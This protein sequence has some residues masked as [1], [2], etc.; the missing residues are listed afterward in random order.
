M[1]VT[2]ILTDGV[3]NTAISRI[4][5]DLTLVGAAANVLWDK[6]AD[7]LIFAD[8]AK[9]VFGTG[10][11]L[12]IY[13]DGSNSYVTNA[14][15]ALKIATETSGIAITLGHSTSEVTVADNLTVTGTLTGTLATAAQGSVTSL[16]TL[17]TLTVDNI[18][19]NGT[20]IGHTSDT[21]A[22][23]ISSAGVVT[24]SATD[25]LITSGTT[26]HNEDV[27][28][29][30]ANY[31][32][33]WDKSDNQLE[34]GDN[35]KAVFG[36]SDD[37]Q[38]Y[39][40][41]SYS[42][43]KDNG[44]GNL[45]LACDDFQ[46]TNSTVAENYI[47]A[48]NNGAVTLYYDNNVR[49]HTFSGG[50]GI[51]TT[52]NLGDLGT[53]LHIR[54]SDSGADVSAGYDNLII[55]END[56][57]GMTILSGTGNVGAIAFGDSGDNDIGLITYNHN[58][59]Y[60]SFTANAGEKLRITS[61]GDTGIGTTAPGNTLEV[62]TG[63]STKGIRI[64]RYGSGTYY[65]D[66]IHTDTPER[67]AFKVGTG[68]AIA[69]IMA[70][71]GGGTVGIGATSTTARLN[72]KA[73][74]DNNYQ[75][76]L[77][78]SNGADGFGL[79]CDMTDGDLAFSRYGSS[80]FYE[81]MRIRQ[82]GD[83]CINTVYS[84]LFNQAGGNAKLTVVGESSSTSVIGNVD[85]AITIANKDGTLGNTSGLHFARAD[86]DES[87]N[88]AGASIV[89][90]FVAAQVTGQYP[91]ADLNFCTSTAQNAAPSL[92]MTLTDD[93]SLGIGVTAP[94]EKLTVKGDIKVDLDSFVG[95]TPGDSTAIALASSGGSQM[96]FYRTGG[97]DGIKFFVHDSGTFHGEAARLDQFG[98]F[99]IG[100]AG[101]S[102][103][104]PSAMSISLCGMGIASP[105]G[106]AL[107]YY[108]IKNTDVEAHIG[109]KSGTDQ[110]WY[111]GTAHGISGIGSA[112]VYQTNTGAGWTNVSDERYKKALQP[113]TNA[114]DK[115]KDCRGM[116]GLYKTDPDDRD[117]RS[118]LIAQD[119]IPVLPEAVDQNTT[120]DDDV[121]QKL[122]LQYDATIP[123]LVEAIK[124]LREQ[125]IAYAA[126]IAALEG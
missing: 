123:L 81:R 40:T 10:N 94:P 43:I 11:D 48:A 99:Q 97:D 5:G 45:V 19:I 101:Q 78:Q 37:L 34:F 56:N 80:T 119:W 113:I 27:T 68:S 41:G 17:T 39:H 53:G 71:H 112:G 77:Q 118:F 38:I 50:V 95:S 69:E 61:N 108:M 14:V 72:V 79:I 16:G 106:V 92:K 114:L 12:Q 51:T 18:I 115:I 28:F 33:L 9:A 31:N 104:T 87:P 35:A 70:I 6:S 107:Q 30:G 88:F 63:N 24:L 44:T 7:D 42:L 105:D 73:A 110:N 65:S 4:D 25:S 21:D 109:F 125:N 117:R 84:G 100:C 116:T 32:V 102:P 59:N 64:N 93:G 89:A 3:A 86:T 26:V 13:H 120:D 96:Q 36:A 103:A 90:Q 54:Y 74:A 1:A 58:G 126:R 85:A 15:G 2:R 29:T 55:E 75:L 111:L 62:F 98:N 49:L 82:G 52:G 22:I 76:L 23:A 67:L 122:G 57:N 83:V 60:M 8:N 124:E 20:N 66:I 121:T 47:T 46:M 91:A